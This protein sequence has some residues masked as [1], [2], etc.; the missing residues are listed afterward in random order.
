MRASGVKQYYIWNGSIEEESRPLRTKV[1]REN[2]MTHRKT[3]RAITELFEDQLE[4][5]AVKHRLPDIGEYVLIN[6][7]V[8]VFSRVHGGRHEFHANRRYFGKVTQRYPHIIVMETRNGLTSEMVSDI[9]VG[10]VQYV[11]LKQLPEHPEKL[12]YDERLLSNFIKDFEN[13][14][15]E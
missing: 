11:G 5:H 15:L 13:L 7:C 6:E 1:K 9:K 12:T 14:L 2:D 3:V 10:L 8:G 4:D